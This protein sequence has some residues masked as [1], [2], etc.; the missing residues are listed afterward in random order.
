[1][2]NEYRAGAATSVAKDGEAPESRQEDA[3]KEKQHQRGAACA[4]IAPC[5]TDAADA[6]ADDSA[7][8]AL[9]LLATRLSGLVELKNLTG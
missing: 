7:Y 5:F 2:L 9:T 3:L 1:M 6:A 8:L 4:H